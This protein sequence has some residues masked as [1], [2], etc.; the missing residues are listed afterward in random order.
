MCFS[1]TTVCSNEGRSL[2]AADVK[3]ENATEDNTHLDV[4]CVKDKG[5]PCGDPPAFPNTRLHGN[6]GFEMGDELLYSCLPGHV[7]PSGHSAFSLLCDSCGEWYGLV[8]LCVKC[9]CTICNN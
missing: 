3:I 4:F 9:K 2:K 1:R 7:M 5:G 8:Q 6:T